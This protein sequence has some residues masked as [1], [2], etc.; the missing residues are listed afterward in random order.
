MDPQKYLTN[1]HVLLSAP[2]TKY[3]Q[4]YYSTLNS[5]VNVVETTYKTK[6]IQSLTSS[7]FGSSSNIVLP[8][9]SFLGNTYIYAKLT[10]PAASGA[11]GV[12][13][14]WLLASIA[15]I[16]FQ[17]GGSNTG[18]IQLSGEGLYMALMAQCKTAEARSEIIRQAGGAQADATADRTLYACLP[19]VLPWS[20]LADKLP[21]DS[22]LL[23]S[24]ITIG[25]RFHPSS[26]IFSGAG[27]FPTAFDE[28]KITYREG[29]LTDKSLS[30]KNYMMQNPDMIANYPMQYLQEY[31][32]RFTSKDIASG[33]KAEIPLQQ[34][35]NSDLV[36]I[37]G[38]V[39]QDSVVFPSATGP[40]NPLLMDAGIANI[41]LLYNGTTIY[42][43]DW[44]NH[45]VF[46]M[47]GE[48][49]SLVSVGEQRGTN[50]VQD[51]LCYP[52]YI[53]FSRI[54]STCF[55]GDFQ[56]VWRIGNQVLT[57]RLNT[58]GNNAAYTAHL[59]YVYN[60]ICEVKQGA[61]FIMT[62]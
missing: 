54:R 6:Y 44:Y 17:V 50:S 5:Q 56:N 37:Y 57:L 1:K 16:D 61:S 30:L 46:A 2:G 24:P 35:M 4:N 45:R 43:A 9:Q 51:R 49:S 58:T 13:A 18:P 41:E 29:D 36:G 34:F 3:D 25:V 32:V 28:V 42:Q 31:P 33:Q 47:N 60:T 26:R 8:N 15:Q 14:G 38:Y 52:I 10:L 48:G 7:S 55:P 62:S 19:L 22:S 21:F 23:A 59:L 39:I 53:D 20:C 40:K 27:T 11:L 12:C